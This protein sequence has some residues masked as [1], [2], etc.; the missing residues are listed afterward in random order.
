MAT[1]IDNLTFSPTDSTPTHSTHAQHHQELARVVSHIF[2]VDNYGAVGDGTTN[3]SVAIQ[4]AITACSAAGGGEVWFSRRT[5]KCNVTLAENVMLVGPARARAEWQDAPATLTQAAAG[6]VVDTPVGLTSRC[7]VADLHIQGQGA[8]VAG[9]GIRF[10]NVNSGRIERVTVVSVADAGIQIDA[11]IAT[12]VIDCSCV[13]TVLNRARGSATG[14]L[15][16]NGTDHWV[17]R[18]E[19][20]TSR[21]IEGTVSSANLYCAAV[22]VKGTNCFLCD[23][24]GE[25]SDT[26]FYVTGTLNRFTGCRGDLNYGHGLYLTSSASQ[27]QFSNCLGMSNSQD[28]TNTYDSFHVDNGAVLNIFSNCLSSTVTVKV[29]R[30]GFYDDAQT[31]TQKNR[32]SNCL[33]NGAATGGYRVSTNSGSVM[34]TVPV[35]AG[36]DVGDANKTVTTRVDEETLFW[37]TALSTNRTVTLSTTGG[38]SGA[39]FK[40]VRGATATGAST[41]SVGGLKTL[42]VGQWAEVTFTAGAW[43]LT[44]FGSL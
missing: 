30:Y 41:L 8:A 15:D 38:Y 10:R 23:V 20:T 6:A 17:D 21:S 11:G 33:D 16:I 39:K 37:L 2:H 19:Y 27:N 25:I 28:T 5:Y 26:G 43:F 13:N 31:A 9:Q 29:P 42:A 32:Y 24:V 44:G 40:I 34:F 3:D 35:G 1:P 12:G 18:G 7:G 22:A 4:A 14:A 36:G